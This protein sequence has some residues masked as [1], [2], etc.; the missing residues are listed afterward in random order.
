MIGEKSTTQLAVCSMFVLNVDFFCLF[1]VTSSFPF[2][3]N[4]FQKIDELAN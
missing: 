1:I 4:K 3:P 2:K